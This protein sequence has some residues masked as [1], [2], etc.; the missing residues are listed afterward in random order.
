M[1]SAQSNSDLSNIEDNLS[2]N[3][4]KTS[5][6]IDEDIQFI[7]LENVLTEFPLYKSNVNYEN[8]FN[9]LEPLTKRLLS[10]ISMFY[11]ESIKRQ[12]IE[13]YIEDGETVIIKIPHFS[14][15]NIP[16]IAHLSFQ[17]NDT[18]LR[19]NL[20]FTISSEHQM[21]AKQEINQSVSIIN[22]QVEDIDDMFNY[23]YIMMFYLREI[24]RD[25]RYSPILTYLYH[26]NDIMELEQAAEKHLLLFGKMEECCVCNENCIYKTACN[27]ILC[28]IC[29]YKLKEKK[30]P[31]CRKDFD[32]I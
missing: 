17:K 27:H 26:K 22:G 12:I 23:I 15:E 30:C 3:T 14:F 4:S 19:I 32:T 1:N 11:F 10:G 21:A 9:K 5:Y 20:T 29:F 25:F 6:F 13:E 16:L 18:I 28:H 31:I 8:I 24:S 7:E 2:S